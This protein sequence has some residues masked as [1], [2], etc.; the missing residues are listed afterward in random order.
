[1]KLPA[2][3]RR[4]CLY[5]P[6][7]NARALEKA[8]SLPADTLILDLEDAVAP[9][10]KNEAREQVYAHV[11]NGG[12]GPREVVVRI[13][14]LESGW[15]DADVARLATSGADALL[16]PKVASVRDVERF[17]AAMAGAGAPESMAL[18][19]MIETP[20][21]ILNVADIAALGVDTRLA[22]MVMGTNDLAKE[23][24]A[25][26]GMDRLGFLTG[27]S[28]TVMAARA[29]GLVAIDGVYNRIGDIEGLRSECAQGLELGFEGKTA[30]HPGQIP[31]C[32]EV[33]APSAQELEYAQKVVVAFETPENQGKGVIKVDGQMT[34]LLH[35]EQARRTIAMAALID[36]IDQAA[37][38]D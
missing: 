29:N 8:K 16:A 25:Q 22:A 5:M 11:T 32:N 38:S 20:H 18:W 36:K 15:G 9:E 24:H 37:W 31:V 10:A 23:M 27:L 1:M 6:G 3:P 14:A 33:F 4:S 21:A 13:N 30:I 26:P 2:R 17:H 7:A 34:E 19:I 28:M 12:Y 35:L